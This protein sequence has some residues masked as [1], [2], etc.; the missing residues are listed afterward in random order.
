MTGEFVA[1]KDRAFRSVARTAKRAAWRGLSG[2][3]LQGV[4]E[5]LKRTPI[6]EIAI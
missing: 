2:G 6:R 1:P 3:C 5:P 4:A